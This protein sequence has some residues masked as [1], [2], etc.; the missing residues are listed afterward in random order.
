MLHSRR[1]RT[2]SL[3]PG[4]CSEPGRH[5]RDQEP[6][7]SAHLPRN[8]AASWGEWGHMPRI[9]IITDSSADLP[10]DVVSQEG[11]VVVPVAASA[12]SAAAE[13]SA[14]EFKARPD[15]RDAFLAAFTEASRAHDAVVAILLSS[16]L[17][18]VVQAAREAR[19]QIP[20]STS[21]EIVDSRSASLGLGF[22]VLHAAALARRGMDAAAIAAE[23]RATSDRYHVVFSVESV[24][25]LRRSGRIGR[26]AAMI[27]EALQ[28]KPLLRIDE[29][30]IVP[31]E[32]ARTRPRAMA[33]LVEFV[34]QIPDVE[35]CAVLYSSRERDARRLADAILASPGF[36]TDRL[37]VSRIG[38]TIAAHVGPGALGVAVVEAEGP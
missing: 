11:I 25:H 3:E 38:E 28:L 23:I 33:E 6:Y 32:R 29:G 35:R 31:Y 20:G 15:L 36:R 7:H 12:V 2:P 34:Q 37:T 17:G 27:A 30:Q 18:S 5:T 4:K 8:C 22:Q 21:I 19:D 26:S 1:G 9:A 13:E 14:T 10:G 24:E 16:R